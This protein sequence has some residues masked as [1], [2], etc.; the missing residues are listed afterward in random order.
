MLTAGRCIDAP[1]YAGNGGRSGIW[2]I[3]RVFCLFFLIVGTLVM[4]ER[5][6]WAHHVSPTEYEIKV[7]F[8]FNFAKFV[9]WPATVFPDANAPL[10]LCII[11]EG[12]FA[13]ALSVLEGQLAQGRAIAVRRC[14][15]SR[16]PE[17]VRSSSF[18]GGA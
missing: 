14:D 13:E 2:K 4:G 16:K 17:L 3:K 6:V 5:Q 15:R 12:P 11:G 1:L 8:P 10:Q 18:G 9:E 7:A